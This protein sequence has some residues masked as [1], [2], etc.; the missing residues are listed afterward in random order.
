M[1]LEVAYDEWYSMCSTSVAMAMGKDSDVLL[2]YSEHGISPTTLSLFFLLKAHA[3]LF[4][5]WISFP[6]SFK[7]ME[8][9][10]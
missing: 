2:F 9:V 4:P 5:F 6:F 1:V 7:S 8:N 3:Q 10:A